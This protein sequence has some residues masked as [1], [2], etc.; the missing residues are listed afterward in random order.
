M[1]KYNP[2]FNTLLKRKGGGDIFLENIVY[3]TLLLFIEESK[4]YFSDGVE[5]SEDEMQ[6]KGKLKKPR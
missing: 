4:T 3:S 1:Q 6:W 2:A 5:E